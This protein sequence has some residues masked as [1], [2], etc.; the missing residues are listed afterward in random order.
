[1]IS[2]AYIRVSTEEQVHGT[3]LKSQESACLEYAKKQGLK[4][5]KE[6]IFCE[7]GESAKLLDRTQLQN[8]LTF[9]KKNKGKIDSCIV[10]KVDRLARKSEYHHAIKG[11][12]LKYGV[13]LKSVTEPID[14]SPMGSLME[15][16][17]AAFAQFDNDIR[18]T[19]TVTGMKA[20]TMQGG[21]VHQA[22]YGYRNAKTKSGISS[23]TP[24]EN[25]G[26][27]K[28][29]LERFATGAYSVNQAVELARKLGI[30]SRR[31]G[32]YYGW[33]SIKQMLINP[34]YAGF[35]NTSF[36]EGEQI[37]G[38]HEA[39]IT[40]KT[41]Y[42]IRSILN[43][44]QERYSKHAR[45][46][47]P[48]RG[49][50]LKCSYCKHPVTGG[51]PKG[52]DRHYPRY[53]CMKCRKSDGV[54]AN[55]MSRDQTHDDFMAL[56]AQIKPNDDVAKAFRE[57]VLRAWNNDYKDAVSSS[58]R[59]DKQVA[60]LQKK[61]SKVIDLFIDDKL[62]NETKVTKL[63]QI[64]DSMADLELRR[65]ELSSE[66]SD[67]EKIVDGAVQFLTRADQFWNLGDIEVRKQI[68]DMIFPDGLYYDFVEGFG[69]VT[70]S[71]SHQLMQKVASKSD[72]NPGLVTLTRIELVLPD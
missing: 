52:R 2:I 54:K 17:L 55:S 14:D 56:L 44:K 37:Q 16:V 38:V 28:K 46:D 72:L 10:W 34:L 18:T 36:T 69:T 53:S 5:K 70:L 25:A 42:K 50:F 6:H 30:V 58:E 20:R 15:G 47:W 67:K 35:V 4:L 62:D 27:V 31:G 59:I 22:V 8:L 13:K 33:Q 45:E 57:I 40:P 61:K 23:L 49:G 39:I 19:R 32:K 11:V 26:T 63:D 71:H 64:Q 66:V 7:E 41:H 3:S 21:W 29:L 24:D 12:L 9:V 51:S 65:S 60:D 43:G 68:Q 48:L 1:M